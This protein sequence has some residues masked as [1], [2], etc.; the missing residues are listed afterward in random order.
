MELFYSQNIEGQL[1]VLDK[2]ESGHLV[3]VL[4]HKAGDRINVIDGL[5][6]MYDCILKDD[7]PSRAVAV[8]QEEHRGWGEHPY[9]LT[10][11]VCPTKNNDRYEWFAEKATEMGIDE[12]VP[13]IGERS[14]R[15][16]FKTER[17]RKILV[18]AAKQSLKSKVPA[19]CEPVS[20]KDFI[21][22]SENAD[23]LK[24]IAWCFENEAKRV[25][26]REAIEAYEGNNII[27]MVGPE[28]DFSPN[29]AK[30]AVSA[31]F[32]P[33]ILGNSRLRTETAALVSTAAIYYK[34]CL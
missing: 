9:K 13:V 2:E 7:S 30:L 27:V 10:L 12:I 17:L 4:R 8:I 24:L 33:V 11:A 28:G 29:E 19:V 5:G 16:V 3:R 6:T 20:V 32:Q 21:L 25:S 22:A 34:F 26:I 18:S 23:S 31:G 15:K 1:I 14:E